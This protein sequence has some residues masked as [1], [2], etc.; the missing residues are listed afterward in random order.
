M[1]HKPV[2]LKEVLELLNL[3]PGSTVVDG[4]LGGGGHSVEMMMRIA[5]TGHLI[6]LDQDPQAIERSRPLFNAAP[7][8]V[9]LIHKNF[10]NIADA[11]IKINVPRADAV[12]LDVGFSSDQ[13]EDSARGFSFDREGPLDMRMNP[14]IETTAADLVNHLPEKE[15]ADLIFA[16]GEEHHSRRIAKR[17]CEYRNTAAFETTGELAEAMEMIEGGP[18]RKKSAKKGFPGR[19]HPATRV[20]QALRIAVN[21][22]LGALQEGLNQSWALLNRGGR[23][24]VIS[25]H[26]LEDRIVKRTFLRWKDEQTGKL[27]VKKPV[28]PEWTEIKDNPRARS[29]KLRV[30][31]KL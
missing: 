28:V 13:L 2:L 23:L 19:R 5:P 15:L 14:E 8:K 30:V 26:S 17:L 1:A 31:E 9:D 6:A 10:R 20:F 4:T 29:A 22:E 18:Y 25:F 3:R 21:D 11:L 24:G 16:Y 12:L 7:C 27:V